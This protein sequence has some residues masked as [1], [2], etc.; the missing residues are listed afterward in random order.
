MLT[1]TCSIEPTLQELY[2]KDHSA[3][4][5]LCRENSAARRDPNPIDSYQRN[6]SPCLVWLNFATDPSC[7]PSESPIVASKSIQ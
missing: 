6:K 7:C 1:R 3:N 5:A 2:L 4:I